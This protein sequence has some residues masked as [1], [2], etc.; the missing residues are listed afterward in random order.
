MLGTSRWICGSGHAVSEALN[1]LLCRCGF[2][3]KAYVDPKVK[4]SVNI[5]EGLLQIL[6]GSHC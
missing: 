5:L 4:K 2:R 6:A 1:Y 3:A